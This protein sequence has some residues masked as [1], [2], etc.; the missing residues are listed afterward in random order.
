MTVRVF[1]IRHHGPGSARALSASLSAWQPDAVLIEGPPEAAP[2][3]ALAAAAGMRPPVAL[4]A[5]LPAHPAR[6]S[7]YPM[8]AWS[9]EWVA[10]RHALAG[11]VPVRM[12]DLPA[13]AFLVPDRDRAGLPPAG[14]G[15]RSG[16]GPGV[17]D[18][19][20]GDPLARLAAAAGYD[21]PERWWE[22][23]V[24]HRGGEEPWEAITEA[25]AAVRAEVGVP[26]GRDTLLEARRE[27]A[28][29]RHIRAA[30]KAH[31]RVAVVCGAWHAPALV[32]RGPA[33]ADS[34]LLKGLT[35]E[36]ATVTWVPWTN[37][38]LSFSSGYGAG[39]TSPGWY[40]HL[41]VSPDRPVERWMVKVAGLLRA[42]RGDA[43][44]ASVID[45]VRLAEALAALRGRPLAGLSECRDAARAALAGGYD[46]TLELI[47]RRLV[48]GE[49]V[50]E[51]P[52]DTP[53]VPLA[54]DL[55]GAQR[56]LRLKPEAGIRYLELDLRR[57]IDLARSR[58]LHRLDLLA[59]PWGVPQ[60]DQRGTGT[61]REEWVLGWEPELAVRVIEASV[62][63][64]TVAGAA[65]ARVTER[66][67][68][69][70][71][72]GQVTDL[73]ERCLL[74]DLP[75]A[76]PAVMAALD[77]R[78][79][80]ATDVSELMDAVVPLARTLRYGSVRRDDVGALGS[81]VSGIV[82][83]ARAS[84]GPA[85]ASL[86][87]DAAGAA[88]R[89]ISA[90]AS[91]LGSLEGDGLSGLH[92]EWLE[93]LVPLSRS[94]SLHGLVAG[95]T[96]RLLLDAGRL[97]SEE[98]ADRLSLALSRG[99]RPARG[100]AWVEGLVAGSGLLLV[101]DRSLLAVIDDW[102]AGV[103]EDAF[104]EVLPLLRRA[105]ADFQPAERRMIGRAAAGL[106][107]PAG[108]GPVGPA[109]AAPGIDE[110]RAAAV[111]PLLAAL[112]GPLPGEDG[113]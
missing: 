66:A 92:G 99:E 101:H 64:T 56:R 91:A 53:M 87:D 2:V 109:A 86:D 26:P 94:Q 93:A 42:E 68:Q 47:D 21:D 6:S 30:E 107:A 60:P 63:G 96:A 29:R 32:E 4:L 76:L 51:V 13:A 46:A 3:L 16:A 40:E 37:G 105:F 39:V 34:E 58:L 81:V 78:A 41:F 1:G 113:R 100:A 9:P 112:L 15:D 74:A 103:G 79:A 7:F 61:F 71:R 104:D 54:A 95:R 36:K 11:S 22:D 82:A 8:A 83:R 65:T 5:Y 43:P 108:G 45:A 33:R 62:H 77:A 49:A 59:I 35:R 90:V 48:V 18:P 110:E 14:E 31:D 72:L 19:A 88:G 44:P 84:L 98:V 97:S 27:A 85:C 25:M 23:V 50:G 106:S 75:D 73:I 67:G 52:A 55:A 69:G 10:L 80:L 38:R 89:R 70:V 57:D 12:I 28:M 24:E 111:L 102:L 17:V 20:G